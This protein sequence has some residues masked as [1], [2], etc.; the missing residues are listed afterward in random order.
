MA[1]NS[2]IS[3]HLGR[4]R[5]RWND[6]LIATSA[7]KNGIHVITANARD[8]ELLARYCPLEWEQRV[9]TGR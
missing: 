9:L 1:D 2:T 4:M 5:V 7:A 8:Y 3:S 6:A